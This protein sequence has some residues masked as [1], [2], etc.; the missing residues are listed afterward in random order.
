MI[1][2]SPQKKKENV[3]TGNLFRENAV[4]KKTFNKPGYSIL[5]FVMTNIKQINLIKK[6]CIFFKK[7]EG[8]SNNKAEMTNTFFYSVI[9]MGV[10]RYY[11]KKINEFAGN[12]FESSHKAGTVVVAYIIFNSLYNLYLHQVFLFFFFLFFFTFFFYINKYF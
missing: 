9:L 10:R 8:V 12:I 7:G 3:G 4:I 5:I 1:V 6:A 11:F 2:N